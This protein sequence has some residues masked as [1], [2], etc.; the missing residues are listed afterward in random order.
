[1]SSSYNIIRGISAIVSYGG[2]LYKITKATVLSEHTP[3]HK[4]LGW[5]DGNVGVQFSGGQ[6]VVENRENYKYISILY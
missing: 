5:Y 3:T 4:F 1:M 6:P 2:L